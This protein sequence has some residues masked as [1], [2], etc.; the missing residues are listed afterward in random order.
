MRK[1]SSTPKAVSSSVAIAVAALSAVALGAAPAAAETIVSPSVPAPATWCTA[2]VADVAVPTDTES[3]DYELTAEGILATVLPG[4]TFP[5]SLYNPDGHSYSR[6][7]D[8]TALLP[9]LAVLRPTCSLDTI[10]VAAVCDAGVPY[11]DYSVARP[12]GL[13][14]EAPLI[15]EWTGEDYQ[16]D[17]V[18][19]STGD[20]APLTGRTWWRSIVANEDGTF[21]PAYDLTW[22]LSDIDIHFWATQWNADHTYLTSFH[23]MVEDV[24]IAD[25]CVISGP[26]HPEH[27]EHPV[28]PIHPVVPGRAV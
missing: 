1:T 24:P 12:E 28:H 11:V 21:S 20:G 13:T 23:G 6:T 17:V 16:Y 15:F 5:A 25:P 19:G 8:T 3:I 4:Y 18:Y 22:R 26:S 2:T 14:D 10:T 7:G 27:P 9:L